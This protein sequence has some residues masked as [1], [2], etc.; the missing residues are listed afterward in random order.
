MPYQDE[1]HAL[2]AKADILER[3]LRERLSQD[4][5][6]LSEFAEVKDK[7]AKLEAG[8]LPTSKVAALFAACIGTSLVASGLV[9]AFVSGPPSVVPQTTVV[10]LGF[11][12]EVPNFSKQYKYSLRTSPANALISINGQDMGHSPV[13]LYFPEKEK[14]ITY[15]VTTKLDGYQDFTTNITP[16]DDAEG[17]FI[18]EPSPN[19][20]LEITAK[21]GSQ[22][23]SQWEGFVN[24]IRGSVEDLKTGAACVIETGPDDFSYMTFPLKEISVSCGGY[25]LYNWSKGSGNKTS[26]KFRQVNKDGLSGLVA[27]RAEERGLSTTQPELELDTLNRKVR[28]FQNN[29]PAWEIVIVLTRSTGDLYL[30]SATIP[31]VYN[32]I[33]IETTTETKLEVTKISGEAKLTRGQSCQVKTSPPEKLYLWRYNCQ[34]EVTCG[35]WSLRAESNH[36]VCYM[37][38]DESLSSVLISTEDKRQTFT[39]DVKT[40]EA[41]L[42]DSSS[43][44]SWGASFASPKE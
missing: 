13:D 43:E 7:V 15:T 38:Q 44:K 8:R 26:E 42:V 25:T 9:A 11:T 19:P 36:A 21:P 28:L 12:S 20:T 14:P 33:P 6:L 40:G 30:D 35:D 29:S 34:A 41:T 1:L 16:A 32:P 10:P 39:L 3:A 31:D 18:L 22:K 23:G 24:S 4:D 5:N 2:Y 27:F 17:N 37:A